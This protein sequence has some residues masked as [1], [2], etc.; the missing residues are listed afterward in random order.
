[1]SDIS[2]INTANYKCYY[3]V[4]GTADFKLYTPTPSGNIEYKEYDTFTSAD[5]T[6][7]AFKELDPY[8]GDFNYVLVRNNEESIIDAIC[9]D[10]IL[11]HFIKNSIEE[12]DMYCVMASK[13]MTPA[14]ASKDAVD[15][16]NRCDAGK[17][18]PVQFPL[19]DGVRPTVTD[20]LLF[21]HINK[22][23]VMLGAGGVA[24]IV[25]GAVPRLNNSF[26]DWPA[27][28]G[29]AKTVMGVMKLITEWASLTESPFNSTN[30]VSLACKNYIETL[31]IP[32]NV[33]NEIS[34]YQEDMPVYRYFQNQENTRHGFT[35]QATV[36][37]L[38]LNWV[39]ST[40]RYRTLNALVHNHP[41][42]PV[43]P[44]EI[45]SSE[46]Q[47]VESKMYEICIKYGIDLSLSPLE[48]LDQIPPSTDLT[49]S[50]WILEVNYIKSHIAYS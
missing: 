38:F 7:I 44:E 39:K 47:Y 10:D 20:T 41:S 49:L 46:R 50:R 35:E 8:S 31:Q 45:L 32:E 27:V 18:G 19:E 36:S 22:I 2:L 11:E 1:M 3:S 16:I 6:I 4:D 12:E 14:T 33:L 29:V 43:V 9:Y 21:Q 40:H 34:E 48:I 42:P 13:V 24:H 17:Y 25:Y 28:T 5:K 37:P 30:E 26:R 15:F 23:T